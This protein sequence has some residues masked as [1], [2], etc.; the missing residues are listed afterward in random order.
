M[1]DDTQ[2]L[3]ST[4]ATAPVTESQLAALIPLATQ[5]LANQN[6]DAEATKMELKLDYD[7]QNKQMDYDRQEQAEARAERVTDKQAA[8]IE[9]G[10]WRKWGMV[11]A[12]GLLLVLGF[13][14]YFNRDTAVLELIKLIGIVVTAVLAT[15]YRSMYKTLE[16]QTS[17]LGKPKAEDE[18]D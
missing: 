8:R 14:V 17:Q 5:W 6:Q 1:A 12:V 2:S 16:K 18:D 9:R 3:E 13:S 7:L 15:H 4:S 10:E 11:I